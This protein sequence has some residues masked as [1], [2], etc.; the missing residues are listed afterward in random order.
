MYSSELEMIAQNVL[1]NCPSGRLDRRSLPGDVYDIGRFYNNREAYV[2]MLTDVASQGRYY[3]YEQ[4]H[5]A[6]YCLYYK[7]MVLATTNAV[8]CA[9]SQCK[10]RP[11]SPAEQYITMC[12][13]KRTD[14]NLNDRPY[15]SGVSCSECSDGFS[16]RRNQCF[17]QSPL[18]M[19]SHSPVAV[20]SA[21]SPK[22]STSLSEE[23]SPVIILNMFIL[24]LCLAA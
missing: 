18:K 16:C 7:A 19:H 21:Q 4:N 13:I 2:D 24:L 9:Q 10:L 1:A 23:V 12:L 11:N 15:K 17:R 5:C 6:K 20:D 8:G 22:P 14:G 3:N